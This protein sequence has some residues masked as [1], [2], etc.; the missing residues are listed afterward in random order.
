[1]QIAIVDDVKEEVSILMNYI[2]QYSQ[3]HK[4]YTQ[5]QTFND[6]KH[7]LS[8]FEEKLYDIIFLDIYMNDMD[9]IELAKHIREK[10]TKVLIIF[11]TTSTEHAIMGFRL[12]AFDYL[13]KP[14][15]YEQ[16]KNTMDLCS[17][18]LQSQSRYIEVKEK[19]IMV[20]ILLKDIIFT[21]YSNHYIH[22]HTNTNVVRCYMSF[23]EFS[24]ILLPYPQFLC[25]YRNCIINM[26]EVIALK[27][28]DFTM[29]TGDNIPI[30][31]TNKTVIK[32]QYADYLFQKMN[33]GI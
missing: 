29:V 4:L 27:E 26:D 23:P 25:C 8:V 32:Q 15:D 5:I 24:K 21:D 10:D 9:G 30:N 6:G 18:N 3:E 22:I 28:N 13:L 17:Q 14:Y 1:M 31:R 12:R 7:F 11:S 19:R 33:G 2:R 20:K 16:L